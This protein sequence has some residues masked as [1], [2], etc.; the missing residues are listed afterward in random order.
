MF[1][2]AIYDYG[3]LDSLTGYL[4]YLQIKGSWIDMDIL[5]S[6]VYIMMKTI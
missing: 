5:L 3:W 6:C 4:F 2:D 1:V